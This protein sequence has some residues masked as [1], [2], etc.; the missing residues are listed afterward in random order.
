MNTSFA[1]YRLPGSGQI[2]YIEQKVGQPELLGALEE[3][4]GKHGFVMAPFD[5]LS[6]PVILI[7]PDVQQEFS[8]DNVE[9]KPFSASI[10]EA[11]EEEKEDYHV[12]FSNFHAQ[13]NADEFDKIVLSRCSNVVLNGDIP[14]IQLF[15]KAC[16]RYPQLFVALVSTPQ[17]GIW[18]TA[19]PEILLEGKSNQWHT[20][21]LAG[22]KT[23]EVGEWSPKN[24]LEQQCVASYIAECLEHV[25]MRF[26][27]S[28]PTT[29]R[30]GALQHLRSDFEFSLHE[31]QHLGY[32]LQLLHPTPAVCGLPKDKAFDF[33]NQNEHSSRQYYSG[34]MG[35]LSVCD[36]THLYVSLRC[37]QIVGGH[38][39]LYAG[40]GLLRESEFQSEWQETEEKLGTMRD[41]FR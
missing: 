26:R 20:I 1:Y 27:E 19:T 29:V 8:V 40:G 17:S 10:P 24:R 7:H 23:A 22:T 25:T 30:A 32:L 31:P 4:N 14:P 35:P 39:N 9:V 41:L 38:Y 33:I 6:Y 28:E 21:A 5:V 12:D 2:T 15:Y 34:F 13:L 16:K 37:M 11:T 18:L 36:D 3:L